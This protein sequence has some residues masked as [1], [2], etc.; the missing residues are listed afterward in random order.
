MSDSDGLLPP[1]NSSSGEAEGES[2]WY[3]SDSATSDTVSSNGHSRS[4]SWLPPAARVRHNRRPD[5]VIST[6][7]A[8][9]AAEFCLAEM[10]QIQNG[11]QV[12]EQD[13][14]QRT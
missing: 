14:R 12:R 3:D 11:L 13:G 10:K 5:R 2:G 8:R 9:E 1:I 4:D 6:N 7:H